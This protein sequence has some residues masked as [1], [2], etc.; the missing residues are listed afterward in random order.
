MIFKKTIKNN[1]I[2]LKNE[3]SYFWNLIKFCYSENVILK[4][5]AMD[6]ELQYISLVRLFK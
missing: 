3:F 2:E 1:L 5:R 6:W 4:A